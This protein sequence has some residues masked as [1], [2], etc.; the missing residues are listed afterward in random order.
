MAPNRV[1]QASPDR[2]LDARLRWAKERLG[3]QFQNPELL[4]RALTHRS[5]SKRNNERLEFLGD[6]LLNFV[7]TQRLFEADDLDSEGDMSRMRAALVKGETLAELG[8]ELAVESHLI[9]GPGELRSGGTRRSSVLANTV[10]A[11]IGAIL[12]DGGF[13]E[14]E[15]CVNRLMACRL[16]ALPDAA[17]L[18]DAKTRLQEWL[19]GRS[20]SLPE[21]T[22]ESISGEPHKQAFVVRCE[23]AEKKISVNGHGLSRRS[24]EQNAAEQMISTLISDSE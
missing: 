15:A 22:V 13:S 11:V 19:Q 18:K 9:V 24:A 8:R 23:V 16:E 6:A 3:Y 5:A 7:I 4:E 10:E 17:T 21:Y 20:L 12:L 2:T 14:G 1:R